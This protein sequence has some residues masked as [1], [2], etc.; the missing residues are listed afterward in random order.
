MEKTANTTETSAPTTSAPMTSYTMESGYEGKI[1]TETNGA[2]AQNK[3]W[4]KAE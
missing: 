3:H 1:E 2:F 4:G